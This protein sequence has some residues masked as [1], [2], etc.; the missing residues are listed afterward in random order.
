[1]RQDLRLRSNEVYTLCM[2]NAVSCMSH[3]MPDDRMELTPC[4]QDRASNLLV[5]TCAGRERAYYRSTSNPNLVGVA[6][7]LP[8]G[9]QNAA[10]L[11]YF[12]L[13]SAQ[14]QRL[15]CWYEP[16]D[17]AA[18]QVFS[19]LRSVI[20]RPDSALIGS[21]ITASA[22]CLGVILLF[23]MVME[24]PSRAV[25]ARKAVAARLRMA[26]L[27]V[28]VHFFVFESLSLVVFSLLLWLASRPSFCLSSLTS[29]HS[30][31]SSRKHHP[32]ASHFSVR[33]PVW[34]ASPPSSSAL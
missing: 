21:T 17:G 27:R 11:T 29:Y 5:G 30:R 20:I 15:S 26:D 18:L 22:V 34:V 28:R 31:I 12:R 9:T 1:M 3:L 25:M 14:A 4:C 13:T 6:N 19:F 16:T 10:I 8:P 23:G 33:N 2:K 32:Q 24:L 7:V